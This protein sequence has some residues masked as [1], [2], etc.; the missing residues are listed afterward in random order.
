MTERERWTVYP[1]LFLSLGIAMRSKIT[2]SL[3]LHEMT[4]HTLKS[5]EVEIIG[6][7]GGVRLVLTAL[8]PGAGGGGVVQILSG[9]GKREVVL[10]AM[11]RGGLLEVATPDGVLQVVLGGAPAGGFV[12]TR[13]RRG[14][15]VRTLAVGL[16]PLMLG[17]VGPPPAPPTEKPASETAE[18]ESET[19]PPS[20]EPAAEKPPGT[21]DEPTEKPTEKPADTP[22]DR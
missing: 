2:S 22:A 6:E 5:R 18:P 4:C 9:R 7:D 16:N 20:D 14:T 19:P 11:P 17:K 10:G 13:D 3:D 8:A 15:L 21:N 1:L 12:E